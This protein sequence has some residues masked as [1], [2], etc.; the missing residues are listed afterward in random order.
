MSMRCDSCGEMLEYREVV[1]VSSIKDGDRVARL[2]I[3][4]PRAGETEIEG[5]YH[6]HCYDQ[7]RGANPSLPK[8]G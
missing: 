6:E 4:Q 3:E 2:S 5:K 7:M 1:V 8:P